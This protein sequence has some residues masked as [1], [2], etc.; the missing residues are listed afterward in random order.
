MPRAVNVPLPQP[1]FREPVFNEGVAS[2]DPTGFSKIHPSDTAQ[3]KQIQNLLKKDVVT[4]EKSRVA[5]GE[6]FSLQAALGARGSQTVQ[7]IKAAGKIIFHA[8]G[9][10]GASNAGKYKNEVGVADRLTADYQN[11]D[12]ANRPSFLFHLGDVVYDFGESKYYY[13]QFYEPF[14]NYPAPIFAIPGNHDSFVIPNTP[15][16]QTPLT[17]FSNNFCAP[18]PV[19]TPEAASLHRTAMTQPGVYFT[20]DAPFVR[21]IGLFSNS[22]EDPGVISSEGKQWPGVPDF[23]L[24]YLAEQ[25]KQIKQQKYKGA[26]L[27]AVHHP[28]FSYSPPKKGGGAGGNHGSS[29]A[30]LRQIDTIC[31]QQGVYPHAFLSAHAHNYQRYTRTVDFGGKDPYD[32][33]FIVCGDGGHNVNK[34][35]QGRAGVPGQE[36]NNGTNVNY[37]D[38]KPAVKAS[39]LLIEKYD[40]T[41]YG[42][43]RIAVDAQQLRIGFNQVGNASLS[44]S[45]FDLVTVDLET[46]TMVSN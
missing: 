5:D 36:P 41:N 32:V 9:D 25:L 22:L 16:D 4:F 29:S 23:Q 27:L 12:P 28:P 40:D 17:I 18:E 33:P 24:T 42:Y 37:M 39:G 1:V 38:V 11:A 2:L 19:I 14:R 3:Y 26:V 35:V 21:I 34:M 44:Q 13:D 20:L 45:S 10:S 30:M 6:V 46:H 8:L 7:G 43:L 31:Q 15:A